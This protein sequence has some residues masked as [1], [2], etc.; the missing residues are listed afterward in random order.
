MD[1]FNKVIS[2]ILGLV[3]IVVFLSVLTGKIGLNR[4]T[5]EPCKYYEDFNM[6][7]LPVRCLN[8]YLTK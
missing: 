7:S 2:F 3:V 1:S 6:G 8:Y 4:E 5:L